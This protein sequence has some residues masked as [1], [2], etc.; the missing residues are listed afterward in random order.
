[1]AAPRMRIGLLGGSFDPA[2]AAHRH[3]SLT[4]LKRLGLDQVWWLVSP[5]NPLKDSSKLPGLAARVE[6]AK[7]IAQHPRI[8]VTGFEKV[9]E[10]VRTIDTVR[11]LKRRYPEVNF[12]WLMGADNL[13][14]FHRWRDWE[15]LFG[16]VPIAVFDRPG[17]T[18]RALAGKATKRFGF[19]RIDESD[20]GGLPL[21]EPPVW[22]FVT[23]PLSRLS[24]TALRGAKK[25]KGKKADKAKLSKK[26]AKRH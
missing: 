6:A 13:A 8:A 15:Q 22:S 12:V 14:D 11:F 19:A 16:L 17:F 10:S 5:G 20:V 21:I 2:H 3:I 7:E 25:T 18:L 24:S 1:M 26:K 4:A 9:L 23:L